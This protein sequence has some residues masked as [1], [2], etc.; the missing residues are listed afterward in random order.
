VGSLGH[1]LNRL[2]AAQWF[3]SM[4]WQYLAFYIVTSVLAYLLTPKPKSAANET[5]PTPQ[6]G[7]A[8]TA[9]TSGQIRVVFGTVWVSPNVA[10]YGSLSTSP[11]KECVEGGGSKK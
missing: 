2:M 10:W 1:L 4:G 7:E 3:I 8:P 5:G 11:I 6:E 9:L